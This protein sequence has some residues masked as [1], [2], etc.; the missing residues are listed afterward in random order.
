MSPAA[1]KAIRQAS[2][3]SV[4]QM[5]TTLRIADESTIRR[6]EKGERAVSGPASILMELLDAGVWVPKS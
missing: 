6:W 1:F 2:G 5:A 3:R 4:R